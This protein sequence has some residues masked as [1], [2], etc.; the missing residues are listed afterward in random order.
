M[1]YNNVADIC[2]CLFWEWGV[3]GGGG[4]GGGSVYTGGGESGAVMIFNPKKTSILTNL[5]YQM[6]NRLLSEHL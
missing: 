1:H 3:E 4:G 5:S 6:H 2:L